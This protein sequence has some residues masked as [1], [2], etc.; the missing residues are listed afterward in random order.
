MP[1]FFTFYRVL[2]CDLVYSEWILGEP[3]Y[4]RNSDIYK[5]SLT[6]ELSHSTQPHTQSLSLE[7]WRNV[8]CMPHR[9][10]DHARSSDPSNKVGRTRTKKY[11]HRSNG[12]TDEQYRT[13]G[14]SGEQINHVY[15]KEPSV[16]RPRKRTMLG[17][18]GLSVSQT[19]LNLKKQSAGQPTY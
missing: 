7:L 16:D 11:T 19:S 5:L 13:I 3:S 2:F 8:Y 10:I 9:A 12:L 4:L 18:I 15:L 14:Q 1:I 6:M 17:V